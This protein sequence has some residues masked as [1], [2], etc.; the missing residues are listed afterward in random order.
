MAPFLKWAGGK[1]QL[2]PELLKR[3]PRDF[4]HYYEPF[5]GG[6]ALLLALAPRTATANDANDELIRCYREVRDH[7]DELIEALGRHRNAEE[8]FYAV[9]A[10]DP[11]TLSDT[12][13]AAR[14]VFLNRTCFNG[15][16]RVNRGGQF[17]TP[18]GRYK[19][20]NLVPAQGI[21]AASAVLQGVALTAGGYR[22]AL[23]NAGRGDFVYLDPPYLPL[24][25]YSDFRR[26]SATQFRDEHHEE[27]ATVYKELDARGCLVML[28]NSSSE[29]VFALYSDWRVERLRAR[30]NINSRSAGRGPV[31]EVVVTNY[32]HA[33]VP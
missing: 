19:N 26:Y 27:L 10:L 8:H 25:Q 6:G 9:R 2:L 4:N 28:S 14:L 29:R 24:S 23:A 18:Y 22:D 11:A 13:A 17:N 7:P 20:P 1:R 5:L 21:R 30:R 12:E 33:D 3:V 15:L 16:Y 31:D 32:D